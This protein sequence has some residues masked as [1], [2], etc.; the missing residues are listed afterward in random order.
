MYSR[1]TGYYRPVQN[2]NDGK[3]QEY[4][5]RKLYDIAT[6]KLPSERDDV[7]ECADE[8]AADLNVGTRT[9]LFTT[10]TCPN[11]K[12]AASLLDKSGV[13]FEKVLAE[14]NADLAKEL[15]IKQAPTLV[16]ADENGIA[17]YQGVSDIKKFIKA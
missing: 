9:I 11:C 13:E 15:G 5:H 7:C 2:W 10:A 16:V 12:I 1:I 3:V 14:D 8:P 17:K 6:S 4:K